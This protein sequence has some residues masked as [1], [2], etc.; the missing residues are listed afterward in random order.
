M[1]LKNKHFFHKKSNI[2]FHNNVVESVCSHTGEAESS[3]SIEIFELCR[4]SMFALV[5]QF[6]FF[7]GGVHFV[8]TPLISTLDKVI[9]FRG[10]NFPGLQNLSSIDGDQP[11]TKL[12]HF[13]NML[14]LA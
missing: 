14:L 13:S 7:G 8:K 2:F 11:K 10:A 6:F 1:S 9:C 12:P 3:N 5:L 4:T